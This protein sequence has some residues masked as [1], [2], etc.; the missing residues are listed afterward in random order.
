MKIENTDLSGNQMMQAVFYVESLHLKK[1]RNLLSQILKANST[2]GKTWLW[3]SRVTNDVGKIQTF[4]TNAYRLSPSDPLIRQEVKRFRIARK[5]LDGWAVKRCPFCWVPLNIDKVFC[6]YCNSALIIDL[7]DRRKKGGR[8]MRTVLRQAQQRYQRVA[9]AEQNAKAEYYLALA[10]FNL[11]E[12]G[13]SDKHIERAAALQ[14]DGAFLEGQRKAEHK[15]ADPQPS[16]LPPAQKKH[17]CAAATDPSGNTALGQVLVIE[18]S[19]TVRKLVTRTLNRIGKYHVV[20]ATS[21]HEALALLESTSPDL[22]LLDIILP[23][24]NGY[25]ILEKIRSNPQLQTTPVVIL[26]L[27][28]LDKKEN[29]HSMADGYLPKP[30]TADDLSETVNKFINIQLQ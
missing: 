22:I 21:G 26:S 25:E 23:G 17:V 15:L 5:D 10:Y 4:L 12:Q 27:K 29:R 28:D 13:L 24:M 7:D 2:N 30:F 18:D 16:H 3:S 14:P 8:P 20:E 19:S 1:A 9:N 11:G 6:V